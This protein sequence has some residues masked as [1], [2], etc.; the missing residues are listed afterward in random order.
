[1]S[2]SSSPPPATEVRCAYGTQ[3]VQWPQATETIILSALECLIRAE[4]VPFYVKARLG[5]TCKPLRSAWNENQN[6]SLEPVLETAS[7]L[8]KSNICYG[9]FNPAFPT[10]DATCT[11]HF[12]ED[13][14]DVYCAHLDPRSCE[15]YPQLST[16]EKCKALLESTALM[17][18]N[19]RANF[20]YARLAHRQASAFHSIRFGHTSFP[21]FPDLAFFVDTKPRRLAFMEN[22]IAHKWAQ[23]E[24][25][26]EC[27]TC[28]Y[29]VFAGSGFDDEGSGLD[30]FEHF[31]FEMKKEMMPGTDNKI[32]KFIR[33]S[34]R[35]L[36]HLWSVLGPEL[37][38]KLD[39]MA[40]FLDEDCNPV[41]P[42]STPVI[43]P[44]TEEDV[45]H[46]YQQIA[47]RHRR[48]ERRRI[49]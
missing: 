36:L 21:D 31:E 33:E 26:E 7:Q 12:C 43:E 1:M 34:R 41:L 47:N 24:L 30:L 18:S 45:E 22:M 15:I 3:S 48:F 14:V 42:R 8:L 46:M 40:P 2:E 19:F 11:C 16:A 35:P 10:T 20:D 25:F 23:H 38:K 39:F 5:Q 37:T 27:I 6:S 49:I 32:K 28:S 9:C 44:V 13:Y 17:V 4:V 29:D